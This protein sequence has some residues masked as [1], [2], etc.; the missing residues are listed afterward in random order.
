[1]VAAGRQRIGNSSVHP[2]LVV[3]SLCSVMICITSSWQYY[4]M[5]Y[6]C[7]SFPVYLHLAP[8]LPFSHSRFPCLFWKCPTIYWSFVGC[9]FLYH[10][11]ILHHLH[12][13]PHLRTYS[14]ALLASMLYFAIINYLH[15][16]PN[17]LF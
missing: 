3:Q 17:S 1:M 6:F 14:N 5:H 2:E 4:A 10:N 8:F 7:P 15:P 16:P 12:R 9:P 13:H 11:V